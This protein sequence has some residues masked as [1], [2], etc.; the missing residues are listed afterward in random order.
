M[1]TT[2]EGKY[3]HCTRGRVARPRSLEPGYTTEAMGVRCCS[4][5]A[6]RATISQHEQRMALRDWLSRP[7]TAELD[8]HCSTTPW[9]KSSWCLRKL[10]RR[11]YRVRSTM[12]HF[13]GPLL[14]KGQGKLFMPA[15]CVLFL[16][17]FGFFFSPENF[18][19][20]HGMYSTYAW[21]HM[22]V[23]TCILFRSRCHGGNLLFPRLDGKL[24]HLTGSSA[25]PAG[26]RPR[27]SLKERM[28]RP[29][30]GLIQVPDNTH[31]PYFPHV[32]LSRQ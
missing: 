18:D 15:C 11:A 24:V 3:R 12:S 5:S 23:Y 2:S 4:S 27:T 21:M 32:F 16:S 8:D 29:G 17:F 26:P 9:P 25:S 31:T 22:Q 6:Q 28:Q 13:F 30:C 19:S 7:W 14:A 10:F 20:C 1:Y